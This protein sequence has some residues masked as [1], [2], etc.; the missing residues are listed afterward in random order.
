ML[1]SIARICSGLTFLRPSSFRYCSSV[2]SL[3]F[4]PGIAGRFGEQLRFDDARFNLLLRGFR[5]EQGLHAELGRI[6]AGYRRGPPAFHFHI[7]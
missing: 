6:D 2:S 3:I 5:A 7:L 4:M 1:L